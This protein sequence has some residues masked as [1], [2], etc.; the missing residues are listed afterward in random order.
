MA[1]AMYAVGAPV[2]FVQ[3]VG[4]PSS[5]P[6][7][8]DSRLLYALKASSVSRLELAVSTKRP[9]LASVHSQIAF[10][11][12]ANSP[13]PLLPKALASM[14][15]TFVA[16]QTKPIRRI[17]CYGD[18]LTAGFCSGGRQF[19]PYGRAMRDALADGGFACDVAICGHSGMTTHEMACA[20]GSALVDVVGC[21]GKGLRRILEEDG[22]FD[23]VLIMSGTNDMGK[24]AHQDSVLKSLGQLHAI[25]HAQ[26]VPTVALAPPPAPGQGRDRELSR[27]SLLQ[28][29]QHMTH[30]TPGIWAC[31]DPAESLPATD[32]RLWEKDG[33]HFS[34]LG[35]RTL[36]KY[37][38]VLAAEKLF[39][40]PTPCR[41]KAL[42]VE[43]SAGRRNAMQVETRARMLQNCCINFQKV[44]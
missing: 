31:I 13:A 21:C 12:Q 6:M 7:T 33:L 11:Q 35:S 3:M 15:V 37:L 38:A 22:P 26:G 23:L 17:L 30:N 29:V 18:S 28:R 5:L 32:A 25:C 39:N 19:E 27:L 24:G 42:L 16:R 1:M 20:V 8:K 41:P 10:D 44:Y 43:P 34:I 9:A 2:G 40:Q 36:G 4:A 14:P